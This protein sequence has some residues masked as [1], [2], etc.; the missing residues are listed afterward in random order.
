M[1]GFG[2][3]LCVIE[4]GDP[5]NTTLVHHELWPQTHTIIFNKSF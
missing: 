1:Y 2:V 5:V 4:E 3:V